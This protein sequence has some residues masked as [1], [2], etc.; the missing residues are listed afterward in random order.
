MTTSKHEASFWAL[1]IPGWLLLIYL[2][3]AQGITAFRYDLGVAMGTQE[4]AEM[5]TEVGTAFWHGFAFADLLTYIP[6]LL[7]GLMG[8]LRAARWGRIWMAAA[9]GITVYWPIVCLTALVNARGAPGW[10]IADETPYWV[11]LPVIAAWG[12]WGLVAVMREFHPST[13]ADATTPRG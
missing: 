11:V 5:I 8:H 3:Y 4:P 12:A 1:Q 10:N 2:I 7:V 13:P 6:I 9:L